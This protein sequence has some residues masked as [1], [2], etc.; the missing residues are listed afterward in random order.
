M[1]RL[2]RVCRGA[3]VP[4]V[5]VL[6]VA[7]LAGCG[8]DGRSLRPPRPDQTQ[9]IVTSAPPGGV[10]AQL[11]MGAP[12][13]TGTP[14]PRQYACRRAGGADEVPVVAWGN[15][16]AG[17]PELALTFKD[18]NSDPPGYVHWLVVGMAGSVQNI[19]PDNLPFGAIELRNSAGTVGYTGP[20]PPPGEAHTYEL[21]VWT[22][23]EASGLTETSDTATA[24]A[25]IEELSTGTVTILGTFSA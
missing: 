17:T 10:N 23:R 6:L 7:G 11:A 4:A 12:W 16:P 9:S 13:D 1:N 25:R 22:L 20:C 2:L 24:I 5:A 14:I 19:G 18:R 8:S 3:V 15:V 21:T